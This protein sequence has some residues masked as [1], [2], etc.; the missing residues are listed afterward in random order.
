MK[1]LYINN[2]DTSFIQNQ[3]VELKHIGNIKP[4]FIIHQSIWEMIRKGTYNKSKVLSK[5][6]V[7]SL[8]DKETKLISYFGLPKE[9]L[10]FSHAYLIYRKISTHYSKTDFDVIHAMNGYPSGYAAYLLSKKWNIPYVITSHG[11]DLNRC[12]DDSQDI[13]DVKQF[14]SR[15]IKQYLKAIEKAFA[16]IGVSKSFSSL[17]SKLTPNV[18]VNIIQNSYKHDIFKMQNKVETRKKLNI[19]L[20]KF[21]IIFVGNYI[22]LKRHI[23][24]IRALGYITS[25]KLDLILIGGNGPELEVL[26]NEIQTNPS[27]HNI[28]LNVN[29]QQKELVDLYNAAD[30]TIFPSLKDSFGISLVEAMACGCPAIT[31]RTHGPQ[32]IVDENE[33]GFFVDFKSP[34]QIAN[35]IKLFLEDRSLVEIMGNK[36]AISVKEKY[37]KKNHELLDLYK[38]A[39]KAKL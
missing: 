10:Y 23:D 17:I 6:Q 1:I 21:V 34:E 38:K 2:Y 12:F 18:K 11:M 26:N 32:E 30:I 22:K 28:S 36:A 37:S 16:F 35:Y 33:T 13:V 25:E 31:T 5:T 19:P 39:T 24:I 20:D 14:S 3:I 15:V 29:I 4:L 27:I 8:D 9:L 7:E